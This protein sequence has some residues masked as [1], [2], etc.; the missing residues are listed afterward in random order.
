MS[1]HSKWSTIKRKKGAADEKRGKIFSRL[2]KEII[3][4]ARAGGGDAEMNSRLRVAVQ[5]ARAANMPADN[6]TRAIKRGTGEIEGI[7]FEEL[8]YEAYGPGGVAL[9]IE[10]MTD[11][12][13]RTTPE[14]RHLLEKYGGTMAEMGSVSWKFE[15]K[16]LILVDKDQAEEDRLMEIA[17]DA[18]ADDF[19]AGDD[20]YEITTTPEGLAPVTDALAAR[21]VGVAQAEVSLLPKAPVPLDEKVAAKVVKLVEQ[22][23]EHDDVQKVFGDFDISAEVLE[24]LAA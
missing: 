18:G 4:A 22:L 7:Q 24:K 14:I 16:G 12:K 23:E 2:A 5:A 8:T 19:R 9:T 3:V 15:R 17:L 10:V 11:N 6:I 1:G 20:V 21:G 13:N